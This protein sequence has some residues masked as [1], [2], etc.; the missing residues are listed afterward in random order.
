MACADRSTSR[1]VVAQEDTL[2][3]IA[4]WFCHRVPPHQQTPS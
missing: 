1:S 4:F 3:R 2:I